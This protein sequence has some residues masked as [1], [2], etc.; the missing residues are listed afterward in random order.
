MDYIVKILLVLLLVI[1]VTDRAFHE[2]SRGVATGEAIRIAFV[3]GIAASITLSVTFL[4]PTEPAGVMWLVYAFG[5]A[6][7]LVGIS[8]CFS[9]LGARYATKLA[10]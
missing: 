7:V 4:R 10:T 2:V 5:E 9:V 3:I 6:A 8:Y 1:I